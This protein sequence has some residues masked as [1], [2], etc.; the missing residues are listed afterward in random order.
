MAIMII[1]PKQARFIWDALHTHWTTEYQ[2][3]VLL[4]SEDELFSEL[5]PRFKKVGFRFPKKKTT[6]R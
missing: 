5:E 6:G 3:G 1:S 4:K 2:N